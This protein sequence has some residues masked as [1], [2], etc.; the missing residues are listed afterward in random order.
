[1]AQVAA[2][3]PDA[4]VVDA[5]IIGGPSAGDAVL[6]LSG[7][8]AAEAAELFGV[9]MLSVR[10]LDTPFGSASALKACYAVTSK[11]VTARGDVTGGRVL[12]RRRRT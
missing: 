8:H 12:P 1:M 10:V 4:R 11:A 3:L 5:A 2:G 6:H 9:G 7:D